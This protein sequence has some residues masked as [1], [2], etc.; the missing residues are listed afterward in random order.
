MTTTRATSKL[1]K[2]LEYAAFLQKPFDK[3]FIK[4]RIESCYPIVAASII[5]DHLYLQYVVCKQD[6]VIH[7][8]TFGKNGGLVFLNAAHCNDDS[9]EMLIKTLSGSDVILIDQ[10]NQVEE[11]RDLKNYFGN[12]VYSRIQHYAKMNPD[13]IF[14]LEM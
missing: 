9:K 3:D 7:F 14:Y 2:A 8:F 10:L 12:D 6:D 11:L 4:A 1:E 13:I 5:N